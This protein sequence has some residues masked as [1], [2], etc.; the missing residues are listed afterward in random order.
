[1]NFTVR[2]MQ[3]ND[4]AVTYSVN[5]GSA[6]RARMDLTHRWRRPQ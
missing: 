1:M 4:E 6:A 3:I 5:E 2:G